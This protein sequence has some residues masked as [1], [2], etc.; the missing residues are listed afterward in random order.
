MLEN[1]V[2]SE[3][4][5]KQHLEWPKE[6]L[7]PIEDVV[8]ELVPARLSLAGHREGLSPGANAATSPKA[9]NYTLFKANPTFSN[10]R[11]PRPLTNNWNLLLA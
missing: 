4:R 11:C 9:L 10:F 3:R 1:Q 7:V 6:S 2:F 8:S 5:G